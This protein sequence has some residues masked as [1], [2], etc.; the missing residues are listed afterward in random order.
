ML[1]CGSFMQSIE[2]SVDG[3]KIFLWIVLDLVLSRALYFLMAVLQLIE[4]CLEVIL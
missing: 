3:W 4:V 2:F 1:S